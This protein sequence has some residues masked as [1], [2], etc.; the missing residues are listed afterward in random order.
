MLLVLPEAAELLLGTGDVGEGVVS[1]ALVLLRYHVLLRC[2]FCSWASSD[3]CLR[4]FC[5]RRDI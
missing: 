1:P 4:S 2:F 5:H 3:L